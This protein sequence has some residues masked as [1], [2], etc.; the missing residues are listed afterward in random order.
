M[1]YII[2]FAIIIVIAA[3]LAEI[4]KKKIDLTIPIAVMGI[5]LTIYPFG[6]F[7]KLHWGV[8][9]VC[10]IAII[11]IFYLIYKIVKNIQDKTEKEFI[12]RIFTPGLLVYI[13]FWSISIYLN[14][15]RVLSS[16][17]EF[18]HW[19][20]IV[21]NMF[22]FDSYGTNPETTLLFRGYPPFTAIFEYFFL[23]MQQTFIEWDIIIAMN[24]LY[25]SLLLPIFYSI[26]WKKGLDK[27]LIYV[28]LLFIVPTIFNKDFYTTIY[29]D[30]ILGVLWHIY[31]M[32]IFSIKKKK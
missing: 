11:S 28:P 9:A 23:Q 1:S 16:W 4:L 22:H 31:S 18:S 6:F 3:M 21:K 17:D 13:I 19:G 30:T 7:Q 20:L 29:V 12:K 25:S 27:L 8:Y 24:I 10:A 5:V 26:D 32:L 14:R 2:C 15:G